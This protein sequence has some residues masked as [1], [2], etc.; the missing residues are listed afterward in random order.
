MTCRRAGRRHPNRAWNSLP[1]CAK[2][3]SDQPLKAALMPPLDIVRTTYRVSDFVS[4]Q[5]AGALELSPSFQ[6]RSVWRP[7]EKSYLVDTVVRGFPMPVIFLRDTASGLD[8]LEPARQVVDGQQR[9]R[10]LL[11]FISRDLLPD[12]DERDE[13]TVRRSHNSEVAGKCFDEL[14]EAIRHRILNYEFSVDVFRSDTDDR[15]ILQIFARMNATGVKL[16]PQELRNAEFIGEFKALMY[17][18]AAEQLPRWR[19]WH[20]FSEQDIARMEEVELTSE[21]VLL[22]VRGSISGRDQSALNA[23]YRA[24]EESFPPAKEVARRFRFVMDSIDEKLG[25]VLPDTAFTRKALTYSLLAATYD[26]HYGI[27]SELVK[28]RPRKISAAKMQWIAKAGREIKEQTAPEELLEQI[29]RRTT[30]PATR[31]AL[32]EFLTTPS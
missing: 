6:R 4:W 17:R 2:P 16:K 19:E 31:A 12:F 9:I 7:I 30:H 32:V 23:I 15:E 20:I 11:G 27:G 18:L 24:N 10:T 8:Q 3:R 14:P 28:A 29:S 26:L 25:D 1:A 21:L 13:F 22:M 5:R